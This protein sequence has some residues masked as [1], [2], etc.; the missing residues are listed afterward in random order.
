MPTDKTL[1][2]IN[3]FPDEAT[4]NENAGSLGEDE[5]N[6]VPVNIVKSVN[7]VSPDSNGNVKITVNGGY[8]SYGPMSAMTATVNKD[9]IIMIS[10]V[11]YFVLKIDGVEVAR[12]EGYHD[13]YWQSI[14]YCVKKGSKYQISGGSLN[15]THFRKVEF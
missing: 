12:A 2:T 6:L 14:T 9:T 4:Y 8:S 11:A 3:V 5:L 10:A 1:K 7:N 15:S 13:N